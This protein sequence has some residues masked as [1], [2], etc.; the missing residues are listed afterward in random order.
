MTRREFLIVAGMT[1]AAA[2]LRLWGQVQARPLPPAPPTVGCLPGC[3]P[4]CLPWAVRPLKVFVPILS[5]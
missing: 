4:M 5:K 1:T 2:V 3:L